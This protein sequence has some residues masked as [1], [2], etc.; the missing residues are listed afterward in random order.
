MSNTH[1]VSNTKRRKLSV[2]AATTSKSPS[3][4]QDNTSTKIENKQ[5]E[6]VHKSA[7]ISTNFLDSELKI[8]E[9]ENAIININNKS[10]KVVL[11]KYECSTP[12]P[13]TIKSDYFY[14]FMNLSRKYYCQSEAG[15][16]YIDGISSIDIDQFRNDLLWLINN[17]RNKNWLNSIKID[18]ALNNISQSYAN[19]MFTNLHFDHNDKNWKTII[20]RLNNASYK[21]SYYGENLAK[22]VYTAQETFNG[23][24]NS[25]AH[26]DNILNSNFDTIG[27][28]RDGTYANSI[29]V[30]KK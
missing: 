28:G 2:P 14:F 9:N 10:Y 23:R 13:T 3:V 27:I 11:A 25:P 29:F 12:K 4:I 7:D 19:Y 8:V 30:K 5:T 26:R 17:L 24:Y 16:F 1:N 18:P 6:T 22:W 15:K 20:D 21:Y